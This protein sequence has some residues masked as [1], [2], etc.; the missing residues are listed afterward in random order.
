MQRCDDWINSPV[1]LDDRLGGAGPRP[2]RLIE[3]STCSIHYLRLTSHRQLQTARSP[4]TQKRR[5][6]QQAL[7]L[8]HPPCSRF[9]RKRLH[10]KGL[11]VE[12]EATNLVPYVDTR[13]VERS[14]PTNGRR[15]RCSLH[16]DRARSPLFRFDRL[17]WLMLRLKHFTLSSRRNKS[18]RNGMCMDRTARIAIE[19]KDP[20]FKAACCRPPQPSTYAPRAFN[21][22]RRQGHLPTLLG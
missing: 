8:L 5:P 18:A 21:F 2:K 15:R 6:S 17:E 22:D 10:S 7:A 19:A 9:G 3:Q 11:K 4:P 13:Q 20:V 16:I 1:R 14:R 12:A